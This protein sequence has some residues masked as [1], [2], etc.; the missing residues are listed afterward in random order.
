VSQLHRQ[1]QEYLTIRRA[2][3][4]KMECHEKLLGQF[5]DYYLAAHDAA[6]LTIEH[7]LI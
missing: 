7:A 3:G 5:A 2:M 6:T 4:F 1:L